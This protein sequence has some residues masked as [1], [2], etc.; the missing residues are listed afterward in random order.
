MCNNV[1]QCTANTVVALYLCNS[2]PIPP[3][4]NQQPEDEPEINSGSNGLTITISCTN[5]FNMWIDDIKLI[6]VIA[7]ENETKQRNAI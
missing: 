5:E 4:A 2:P 7:L 1:T 6:L 3:M